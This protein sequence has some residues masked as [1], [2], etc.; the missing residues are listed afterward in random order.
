METTSLA[1]RVGDAAATVGGLYPFRT[2]LVLEAMPS[3]SAEMV[4]SPSPIT[5]IAAPTTLPTA[6]SDDS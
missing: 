6:G 3:S 2:T 4:V 1:G 5:W